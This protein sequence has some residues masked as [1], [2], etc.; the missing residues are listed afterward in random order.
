[1]IRFK[2]SYF[3]LKRWIN[4]SISVSTPANTF[5]W[6]LVVRKTAYASVRILMT[7]PIV[8][9]DYPHTKFLSHRNS[10]PAQLRV[11]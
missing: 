10:G 4:S 1:M 6:N 7:L 5:I 9:R 11:F 3:S 8:D 2:E